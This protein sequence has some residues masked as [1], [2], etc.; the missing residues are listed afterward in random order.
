M[1]I[2]SSPRR[3]LVVSA[4][5]LLAAYCIYGAARD[6]DFVAKPYL[7]FPGPGRVAIRGV[8]K[9]PERWVVVPLTPGSPQGAETAATTLH[10][11]VWTRLPLDRVVEVQVTTDA[12][13]PVP[14]G[15]L[16]FRTEPGPART[17]F[18]F[19]VVGDS[20]GAP[21]RLLEMFGYTPSDGAKKRPDIIV[22]WMSEARPELVLHAGDVVYPRGERSNYTRAFFRPFGPLIAT[23]PIAAAIG[24]HDL[25]S[26]DGAPFLDIF[27][28]NDAP[29]L[30]E[31]KYYSFDYGPLHV[32][33]LD[34]NE[35]NAHALERQIAW[36]RLDLAQ[37]RR[38]WKVALTHVP[39][40]FNCDEQRDQHSK[41]Q[42]Q[43]CEA[44][45]NACDAGGVSVIFAG[46][47]HWYERSLP[48]RGM[49]QII[50]G[51]GGDDIV[52]YRKYGEGRFAKAHS[53]FHHVRCR[54]VGDVM[55]IQ[56]IRDDG[57][58]LEDG[59]G[60]AIFRRK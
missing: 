49:V 11:I 58:S 39:L 36:L 59:D 9:T 20:G 2:L 55:T 52:D 42:Q 1:A 12:G 13:V 3:R 51:G 18:D 45:R 32:A 41:V 21:D 56:A 23:A 46:H 37:T 28:F 10:E 48:V 31:S 22:N 19:V 24:N 7:A 50:T 25:K 5:A 47:R 16:R 35:E 17:P 29:P 38:P 43:I 27:K 57:V 34:S 40:I 26:G 4:S 53:F 54:V 14:G 44:L 15:K 60:A 33:V 6:R 30:S 8:T